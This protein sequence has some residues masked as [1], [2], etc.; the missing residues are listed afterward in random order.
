MAPVL[1][2]EESH[3]TGSTRESKASHARHGLVG[4]CPAL[5]RAIDLAERAALGSVPI[6]L[7]GEHG[8]GRESL[9]RAVHLAGPRREHPF[10]ALESIDAHS[11]PP[12]ET[13]AS[14]QERLHALA[15][16]GT[17]FVRSIEGSSR[18]LQV[19]LALVLAAGPDPQFPRV[20]ASTSADLT[21]LTERGLFEPRL[22]YS[23]RACTI[24]LPPLRERGQDL[25]ALVAHFALQASA[26]RSRGPCAFTERALKAFAAYAWPGNIHELRCV[27]ERLTDF[28]GHAPVDVNELPPEL[29]A[30]PVPGRQTGFRSLAE[31]THSYAVEVF[32]A[33][34]GNLS[35]AAELLKI[36]RKTLRDKL[37]NPPAEGG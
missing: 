3:Q 2:T 33:T 4:G 13:E 32:T 21:Q 14:L 8:T 19:A 31:V 27:V 18:R 35:R 37:K 34:G 30:T 23:L 9:A 28:A 26:A 22:L 20:I 17:L 10:H 12:P 1:E 6:L 16:G 36:S 11:F 25:A 15:H 24:A 7:Q 5:H 29:R